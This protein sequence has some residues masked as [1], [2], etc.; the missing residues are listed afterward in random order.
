VD[1]LWLAIRKKRKMFEFLLTLEPHDAKHVVE[2]L[3][4][5]VCGAVTGATQLRDDSNTD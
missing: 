2:G 3:I 4:D 1:R 5:Q